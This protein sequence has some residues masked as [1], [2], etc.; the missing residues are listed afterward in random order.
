M[1]LARSEASSPSWVTCLIGTRGIEDLD[2]HAELGYWIARPVGVW[3][4]RR[5]QV[6][7]S[8]TSPRRLVIINSSPATSPTIPH[9]AMCRGS[10]V[11]QTRARSP[12][13]IAGAAAKLLPA[14]ADRT[15]AG[16][17]GYGCTFH[18]VPVG[19]ILGHQITQEADC[20][21]AIT[22]LNVLL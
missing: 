20:R 18:I 19:L 14:R 6:V 13:G 2:D 7:P 15:P 3:A 1:D 9:R 8:S 10:L 16:Y 11:S 4:L 17:L 22:T 12:M 5:R 21:V